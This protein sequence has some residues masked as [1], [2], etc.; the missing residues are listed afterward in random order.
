MILVKNVIIKNDKG[1]YYTYDKEKWSF[2]GT[3]PK[4]E[5]LNREMNKHALAFDIAHTTKFAFADKYKPEYDVEY[6]YDP[7]T[8]LIR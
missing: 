8:I 1:E 2:V 3:G 4:I 6:V 5:E 7:T